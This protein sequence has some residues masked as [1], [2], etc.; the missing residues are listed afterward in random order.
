MG[1]GNHQEER[2][3]AHVEVERGERVT[4]VIVVPHADLKGN[5][6][7]RVEEQEPA[8]KEHH[9]KIHVLK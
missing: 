4:R 3:D 2:V 7:G 5:Y 8:H 6:G 1:T 9:C